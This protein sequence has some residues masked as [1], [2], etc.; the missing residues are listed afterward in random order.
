MI[1]I[2]PG[3]VRLKLVETMPLPA[4]EFDFPPEGAVCGTC[5]AVIK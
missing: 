1:E 5:L 3:S 4:V 2:W